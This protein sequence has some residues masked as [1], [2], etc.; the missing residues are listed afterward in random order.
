M[1]HLKY[2]SR[3]WLLFIIAI[4]CFI[5]SSCAPLLNWRSRV[6][7]LNILEDDLKL[8]G[9]TLRHAPKQTLPSFRGLD[10]LLL[11]HSTA[12]V[13]L[14]PGSTKTDWSHYNK[15]IS[16]ITKAM[17]FEFIEL[18]RD[19]SE[20][21]GDDAIPI[22]SGELNIF[23][24]KGKKGE[25][26][27]KSLNFFFANWTKITEP[28][29]DIFL[30][31]DKAPNGNDFIERT[32]L[33]DK[34]K[35]LYSIDINVDQALYRQSDY[36]EAIVDFINKSLHKID[37]ASFSQDGNLICITESM[38][39]QILK[40]AFK[41]MITEGEI[42]TQLHASGESTNSEGNILLG[43]EE[44]EY[45]MQWKKVLAVSPS[46]HLKRELKK[47][48][49]MLKQFEQE[50]GELDKTSARAYLASRREGFDT[51]E[52]YGRDIGTKLDQIFM[53]NNHMIFFG[54]LDYSSSDFD[55]N[56]LLKEK[57]AK[58]LSNLVNLK[59]DPGFRVIS[60]YD[61]NDIIGFELPNELI[62]TGRFVSIPISS[63]TQWSI[64]AKRLKDNYLAKL[65][66]GK[67]KNT[68]MAFVGDTSRLNIS[69]SLGAP[70]RLIRTNDDVISYLIKGNN[71]ANPT[72]K[73]VEKDTIYLQQD[74]SPVI[75][76]VDGYPF[77]VGERN[78]RKDERSKKNAI[79]RLLT[80]GLRGS[81]MLPSVDLPYNQPPNG[82]H[83]DGIK[84]VF[85]QPNVNTAYVLTIHGIA[86]KTPNHYDHMASEI[87][88]KLGFV[89]EL[90]ALNTGLELIEQ[91]QDSL[92]TVNNN[93][94]RGLE[95]PNS[96]GN[97]PGLEDLF[98][99]RKLVFRNSEGK[100]LVFAIIHWSPMTRNLK[101]QLRDLE[102]ELLDIPGL[103]SSQISFA[104]Q[105]IRDKI[106][107]DGFTDVYLSLGERDFLSFIGRAVSKG[108]EELAK[109]KIGDDVHQKNIFFISGS[110]GSKILYEHLTR[111]M[112]DTLVIGLNTSMYPHFQDDILTPSLPQDLTHRNNLIFL[113]RNEAK[114]KGLL[115][116]NPNKEDSLMKFCKDMLLRVKERKVAKRIL[117][118]TQS[119]YMLTNQ[120]PLIGL[121]ELEQEN[122]KQEFSKQVWHA[123]E[124]NNSLDP[125][126]KFNFQLNV[127]A[128][129]DPNDALTFRLPKTSEELE[130]QFNVQNIPLRTG[131]GLEVNRYLFYK[132]IKEIDAS[133]YRRLRKNYSQ[134]ITSINNDSTIPKDDRIEFSSRIRKDKKA[135]KTRGIKELEKEFLFLRE[136]LAIQERQLKNLNSELRNAK[137]SGDDP[138]IQSLEAKISIAEANHLLIEQEKVKVEVDYLKQKEF[139]QHKTFFLLPLLLEA[140]DI[141][142]LPDDIYQSFMLRPDKAHDKVHSNDRVLN[143]IS[144]G[145]QN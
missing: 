98:G 19:S 3:T 88:S 68:I 126:M 78:N 129:H 100:R 13:L 20:I 111:K 97:S 79:S 127:H 27:G 115:Y 145:S 104:H 33:S 123:L 96:D 108:M 39:A 67:D 95:G 23:R 112:L 137:K 75:D 73:V 103:N 29:K 53:L 116:F 82:I 63:T 30:K 80:V 142:S 138:K 11:G 71:K 128:F 17:N 41:S 87:A 70:N 7:L 50:N 47:T 28:T 102:N 86:D 99:I 52:K 136:I 141:E 61:P 9:T 38:G 131:N 34:I 130:S 132:F 107:I 42:L 140:Y 125:A 58:E 90:S 40:D 21:I 22:G 144:K 72:I 91:G 119:W 133:L 74:F 93:F 10:S 124:K 24:F 4:I 94:L 49:A 18:V 122:R 135:L 37:T 65:P 43:A 2:L 113:E 121:K 66:L 105:F 26:K 54:V 76:E 36:H 25:N 14:I 134:M 83:V 6:D 109:E 45:S 57:V 106:V 62:T 51:W 5:C 64:D 84:K 118:K 77:K 120:I 85:Q 8:Q 59:S 69:V 139:K 15:M 55:S 114:L 35:N 32:F 101:N 81:Q 12:N 48:T 92:S 1:K 89:P 143:L 60:F 56:K 110:L 117:E 16:K 44:V 46:I 31:F